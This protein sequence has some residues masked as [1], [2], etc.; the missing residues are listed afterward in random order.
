MDGLLHFPMNNL[1][2]IDIGSGGL[3]VAFAGL[4][5]EFEATS[6]ADSAEAVNCHPNVEKLMINQVHLK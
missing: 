4:E 5:T 6:V 3:V 2:R 1:R